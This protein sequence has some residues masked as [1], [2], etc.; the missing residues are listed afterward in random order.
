MPKKATNI[1]KR[2]DGRWEA[3]FLKSINADG[4]RIYGSVYGKTFDEAT[5]CVES[6]FDIKSLSEILGHS[7]VKTTLNRYVHSSMAQKQK[8][9]DLLIPIVKI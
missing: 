2:K 4:K 7:D 1:Y 9:M 5:R 8:N 3:R 6:G